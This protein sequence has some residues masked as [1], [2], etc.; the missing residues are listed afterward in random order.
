MLVRINALCL[1]ERPK[2]ANTRSSELS[3]TS[4]QLTEEPS[5]IGSLPRAESP[6]SVESD[7]IA[8]RPAEHAADILALSRMALFK[9]RAFPDEALSYMPFIAN[10]PWIS[11]SR[12]TPRRFTMLTIGSRGD[13]QP[14]I[15]LGLRLLQDDHKVTIVTHSE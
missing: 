14:Y 11:T 13:I 4:S 15:A 5:M 7:D 3:G 1:V 9:P 8:G 10:K 6:K 2:L 12:L